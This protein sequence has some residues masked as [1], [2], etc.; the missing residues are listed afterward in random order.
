MQRE[1]LMF[2][3]FHSIEARDPELADEVLGMSAVERVLFTVC[4]H[5]N[6]AAGEKAHMACRAAQTRLG[7]L[8]SRAINSCDRKRWRTGQPHV[9]DS[10]TRTRSLYRRRAVGA[11]VN[12]VTCSSSSAL[13]H[14]RATTR[15][16]EGGVAIAP[17]Q[18]GVVQRQIRTF[19]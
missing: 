4:A 2:D 7:K 19:A 10:P 12:V 11:T 8:A 1:T 17:L 14:S 13:L 3:A 6:A 9:R 15:R 16:R 5:L 18:F